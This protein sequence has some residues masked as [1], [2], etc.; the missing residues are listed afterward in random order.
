MERSDKQTFKFAISRDL[1]EVFFR[2][3]EYSGAKRRL[4]YE[5]KFPK[6]I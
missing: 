5:N 6:N 2:S 4:H 3:V 1:S